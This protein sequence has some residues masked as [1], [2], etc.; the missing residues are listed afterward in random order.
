[1]EQHNVRQTSREAYEEMVLSG[2]G[3]TQ[4]AI[5]LR[6]LLNFHRPATRGEI[7]YHSGITINSVCGRVNELLK[8]GKIKEVDKRACTIT[9]HPA[10]RV[11][12]IVK[13]GAA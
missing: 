9:K 6:F 8:D 7:A 1:M 11:A 13:S 10:Y 4:R 2:R 5:V 3:A 12:P